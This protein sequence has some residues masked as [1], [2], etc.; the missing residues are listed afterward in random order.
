MF[1][2]SPAETAHAYYALE[3]WSGL[4][5]LLCR[6]PV[7]RALSHK[8]K[9]LWLAKYWRAAERNNIT[10]VA[11]QILSA[12]ELYQ[13][14]QSPGLDNIYELLTLLGRFATSLGDVHGAA[15]IFARALEVAES[16]FGASHRVA[17][18]A[19]MDI[20]GAQL[21]LGDY[22]EARETATRALEIRESLL[23]K[24]APA[25]GETLCLL[26][27]IEKKVLF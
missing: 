22:A 15:G 17:A 26:A 5:T 27:Q 14:T 24:H 1:V 20:A 10:A 23:G 25:T 18:D 9:R 4:K 6:V 8:R 7:F 2:P 21:T 13:S 3:D 11:P 12:I 19:L 16:A